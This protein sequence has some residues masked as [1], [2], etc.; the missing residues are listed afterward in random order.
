MEDRLSAL[1]RQAGLSGAPPDLLRGSFAAQVR[2][3]R[4]DESRFGAAFCTRRAAKSYSGALK[5]F[6]RALKGKC[7][8]LVAGTTRDELK[9]IWWHPILK[10]IEQRFDVRGLVFNETELS[11]RFPN[12]SWIYLLGMDADEQQKR[13][14]L[15]QKWALVIIDEAQDWSTDLET[16]VFHV[17]K[18]ACT[19]VRGSIW[20]LGTPGLVARGLFWEVTTRQAPGWTLHEWTANENT[21]IPDTEFPPINVQWANEIA[22]LMALK[23]GIEKTPWFRRNYLREWVVDESALVYRYQAGRNDFTELPTYRH[24]T[25]THVLGCDLGWNATALSVCSYHDH[26]PVLYVRLSYRKQGLDITATA[27]EAKALNR[28]Y[29]FSTWVVDG[30]NKQAVEEMRKRQDIPWR[31]ADKIGKAD[32]IELMNTEMLV[33][34]VK[35]SPADCKDLVGEWTSLIWDQKKLKDLGKKEEKAGLPNHCADA[36]LYPWRFCYPYLST[37]H[38]VAP[39]PPGSAAWYAAQQAE[40]AKEGERM[41]RE[42]EAMLERKKAEQDAEWEAEREAELYG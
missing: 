13:K 27:D 16:L 42:F 26:D 10:D 40:A 2:F 32:F 6:R 12:G 11:V 34:M 30:A 33:G 14:A 18:P 24:G 39:P 8:V 35:V 37:A 23:P 9:R 25:W 28:L 4:D 29:D 15:G 17:L 21:T 3:V 31:A 7:N 38:P 5:A 20:L 41:E 1:E 36:T 19:D 22:E